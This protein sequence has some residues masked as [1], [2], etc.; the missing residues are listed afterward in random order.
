MIY[1]SSCMW[2]YL[3]FRTVLVRVAQLDIC[4][5]WLE[6]NKRSKDKLY[7]HCELLSY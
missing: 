4:F 1:N 2:C 6:L 5:P 3:S 7:V